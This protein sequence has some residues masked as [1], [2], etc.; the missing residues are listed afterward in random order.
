MS[1]VIGISKFP[2]HFAFSFHSFFSHSSMTG[3]KWNI[4]NNRADYK[5]E[6]SMEMEAMEAV[7][8]DDFECMS[9]VSAILL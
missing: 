6:Q 3:T 1:G 5:E 2:L 9:I 8:M 7:F 4:N